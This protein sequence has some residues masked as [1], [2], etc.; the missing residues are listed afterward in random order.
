MSV[1]DWVCVVLF[2]AGVVLAAL[3]VV[4][5]ALGWTAPSPDEYRFRRDILRDQVRAAA[6]K[7]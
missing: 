4:A 5:Q 7:P 6:G 1:T 3:A 2:G